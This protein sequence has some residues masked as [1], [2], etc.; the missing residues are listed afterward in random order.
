MCVSAV[1][2][3]LTPLSAMVFSLRYKV[4]SL[5]LMCVSALDKCS[6]PSSVMLL[7]C[8]R[9]KLFSSVQ[10]VCVSAVAKCLRP[11]SVMLLYP[12]FKLFS[13]Q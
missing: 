10:S 5:Q 2:K 6:T 13:L 9:F 1:D 3:C 11:S 12:R 4:F 8:S 7:L